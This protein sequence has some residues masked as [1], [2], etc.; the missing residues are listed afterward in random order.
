MCCGMR[1]DR[2][3]YSWEDQA[4]RP[5]AVVLA[6]DMPLE[7]VA[8]LI[9]E[10]GP[11]L[12]MFH[13]VGSDVLLVVDGQ[14][15]SAVAYQGAPV[16]LPVIFC[17]PDFFQRF[18]FVGD[19]SLIVL[20][21][22]DQRI[23]DRIDP[24]TTPDCAASALACLG[25]LPRETPCH[26]RLPAPILSVPNIFDPAFCRDLIVAFEN[27]SPAQGGMAS[28]DQAGNAIHKIDVSKKHRHDMILDQ[29]QRLFGPAMDALSRFCVPEMK[30]AFQFDAAYIDRVLIA[31]YDESGGYFRRH[32]DNLATSVAHRQFAMSINLSDD[33]DG[34]YLMF[35]EYN[36]HR[37]RPAAGSGIVFSASLLHEATPVTRGSRYV[38]LTFL[39]NAVAEAA[40]L[41]ALRAAAPKAA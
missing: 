4:G 41:D 27:G 2:S 32:R 29:S 16:G 24:T 25:A 7:H 8:A 31:R 6:G 37:Y 1:A 17:L 39:H 34:G 15:A 36:G 22:R 35:P 12:D 26:I 20:L 18:G 11:R 5:V 13:A 30:K 38:L 14:S 28:I 23:L 40:R 19:H 3:F 9:A 33:Y 21:D 10:F